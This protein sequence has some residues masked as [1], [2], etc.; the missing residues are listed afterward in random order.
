MMITIIHFFIDIVL[1]YIST[2]QS[3]FLLH[4]RL[5]QLHK[6]FFLIRNW[7]H[8]IFVPFYLSFLIFNYPLHCTLTSLLIIQSFNISQSVSHIYSIALILSTFTLHIEFSF[9]SLS[10]AVLISFALT[11]KLIKVVHILKM[12]NKRFFFPPAIYSDPYTNTTEFVKVIFISVIII[13]QPHASLSFSF[14]SIVWSCLTGA[15]PMIFFGLGSFIE[16]SAP[17][18]NCFYD[19]ASISFDHENFYSIKTD[20]PIEVPVYVSLSKS[21]ESNLFSIISNGR[22]GIVDDDSFFLLVDND[23][24]AILHII[25]IEP[26]CVRFQ[27]RGLEYEQQTLCHNGELSVIQQIILEQRD[28]GNLGHAIAFHFSMF[29]LVEKNLDLNMISVSQYNY[30]D[31]VFAVLGSET[32]FLWFFRACAYIAARDQSEFIDSINSTELNSPDGNDASIISLNDE[33]DIDA[34]SNIKSSD[35]RQNASI[36]TKDN[37]E[38]EN[39]SDND[40]INDIQNINNADENINEGKN[41]NTN[42]NV[43][44]NVNDNQNTSS[45]NNNNNNHKDSNNDSNNNNDSNSHNNDNNNNNDNDN[46]NSNND[47]NNNT[48]GDENTAIFDNDEPFEFDEEQNDFIDKVFHY[49]EKQPNAETL[50]LIGKSFKYILCKIKGENR[51]NDLGLLTL[52]NGTFD[53]KEIKG[54]ND[55]MRKFIISSVRY[56]VL[57]SLNSSVDLAPS[58]DDTDDFFSFMKE[59]EEQPVLPI[60]DDNF[61]DT[62]SDIETALITLISL[63][64]EVQIVRF[65]RAV[66]SWAVFKMETESVRG[67][68]ANEAR[69][70][71]FD[72]I[73][74]N[75]RLSIQ[76]ELHFLR[77]ITNQ[78]CN[79]PVGYPVLV[80]NVNCS[81]E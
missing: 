53:E 7:S 44:E 76:F 66:S 1:P 72:A 5:I 31:I 28:F 16:P 9:Q 51:I 42:D 17:R 46:N 24:V 56:G 79:Q 78:S 47:N 15:P 77:N 62:I 29:S 43:N 18:P 33:N 75:E 69:N 39:A 4:G 70:I 14:L 34:N 23:L 81:L 26:T 40:K 49:F 55:K 63:S 22:L 54:C 41:V 3:Y 21:L 2:H 52:F 12:F 80:S 58:L 45:N 57:L 32:T 20:S 30:N 8:Y 37:N 61:L 35:N 50:S 71:L 59:S 10:L 27:V 73:V 65:S 11:R 38:N 74:S 13:L 36:D 19:D 60:S 25:A 6:F 67:F 48:Q 64:N 68:W